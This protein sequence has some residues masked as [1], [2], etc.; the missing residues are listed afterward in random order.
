[1]TATLDDSIK[2]LLN[3]IDQ[4]LGQM[5]E[6]NIVTGSEVSDLLLDMRGLV[7]A[8]EEAANVRQPA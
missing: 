6:R 3:M 8:V 2:D 1:M 5:N 4:S 7:S